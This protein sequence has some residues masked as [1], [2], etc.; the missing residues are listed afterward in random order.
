M[1]RNICLA[2]DDNY[3]I[4]AKVLLASIVRATSEPKLRKIVIHLAYDPNT[5]KSKNITDFESLCEAFGLAFQLHPF[6]PS[7]SNDEIFSRGQQ[8]K[9][10]S[11]TTFAKFYFFENLSEPFLWLDTDIAVRPGWD[12]ILDLGDKMNG[13]LPYMVTGDKENYFNNGVMASIGATPINDWQ[14]KVGK[15]KASV[16]QHIFIEE[17][18]NKSVRIS[19][20]FNSISL[21]GSNPNTVNGKIMHYAGPIKPWHLRSSLWKNC[22]QSGCGWHSWYESAVFLAQYDNHAATMLTS[23]WKPEKPMNATPKVK[24]FLALINFSG[25]SL[26]IPT[27]RSLVMLFVRGDKPLYYHPVCKPEV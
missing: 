26:L 24:R 15:H 22:A 8:R 6:K 9:H 11:S 27:L 20:D 1:I 4:G 12:E 5:L 7:V 13:S 23:S 19:E 17:M 10:I 14:G 2:T 16:E 25:V 3:V 18:K 21:W